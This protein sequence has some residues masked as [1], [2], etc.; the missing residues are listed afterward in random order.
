MAWTSI[1]TSSRRKAAVEAKFPESLQEKP[2]SAP[3]SG[4][5]VVFGRGLG[6]T[7]NGVRKTILLVAVLLVAVGIWHASRR[8][9]AGPDGGLALEGPPPKAVPSGRTLRIG[10]FN[11]HS[12][13]GIDGR[14]DLN[15]TAACLEGFDFVALNEVR[16]A[17]YGYPPNQAATLANQLEMG[18]LFAPCEERYFCQ[19]FGNG[20]LSRQP[21]RSWQRIPLASRTGKDHRNLVFATL[22]YRGKDIRILI[23]HLASR[24]DEDR[25]RQFRMVTELFLALEQPALLLGDLNS[26]AT[27]P[28]LEQLLSVPGVVDPL[29]EAGVR[30][31]YRIDWILARG[32]RVVD[33]G[34]RDEGASDHP[35]VWAELE[36]LDTA[37]TRYNGT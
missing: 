33:A 1:M 30:F 23:T 7:G 6:K 11:I 8:R 13:K 2:A 4:R 14:Q 5:M 17:M 22:P 31:R 10:L 3:E 15:R 32:F 16:G 9:S 29:D 19:Y 25:L 27:D 36:L 28:E 20:L 24:K 18:W 37:E 35:L 21:I 26:I 12:G 34:L